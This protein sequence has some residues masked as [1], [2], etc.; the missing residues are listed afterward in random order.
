MKSKKAI[1]D[2]EA[3]H[4]TAINTIRLVGR[5]TWLQF[6][7]NLHEVSRLLCDDGGIMIQDIGTV[8]GGVG[9]MTVC[10][11]QITISKGDPPVV[12]HI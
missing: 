8:E 7:I 12:I 1:I 3:C 2:G 4:I 5:S 10:G 9:D 11:P 6:A